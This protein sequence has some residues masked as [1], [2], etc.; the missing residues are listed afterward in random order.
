MNEVTAE[1][2]ELTKDLVAVEQTLQGLTMTAVPKVSQATIPAVAPNTQSPAV[3]SNTQSTSTPKKKNQRYK[4]KWT[5][6]NYCY[7]CGKND[8]R[9]EECYTFKTPQE[10]RTQLAKKDRCQDCASRIK[11]EELHSCNPQQCDSCQSSKHKTWL[12]PAPKK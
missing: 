10:K 12:C 7:P 11:T 5:T 3:A 4:N 2:V 9:S 1:E 8:H 6:N